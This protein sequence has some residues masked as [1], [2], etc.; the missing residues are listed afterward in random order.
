MFSFPVH[1]Y[2]PQ[3]FF[4]LN[5]GVPHWESP[6]LQSYGTIQMSVPSENPPFGSCDFSLDAQSPQKPHM[7]LGHV[8][9]SQAK[10][11]WRAQGACVHGHG[12]SGQYPPATRSRDEYMRGLGRM[13]WVT[14]SR[15]CY[16]RKLHVIPSINCLGRWYSIAPAPLFPSWL[17]CFILIFYCTSSVPTDIQLIHHFIT[18]QLHQNVVARIPFFPPQL[19][20]VL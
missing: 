11:S 5:K 16:C 2:A 6:Q 18:E 12:F 3:A 4:E 14:A 9:D 15:L 19:Y 8:P 7:L 10:G 17:F 1:N 20:M 13:S